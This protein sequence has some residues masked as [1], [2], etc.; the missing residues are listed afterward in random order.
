VT[1]PAAPARWSLP[2]I[3]LHWAGALVIP[4]LVVVGWAMLR[5]FGAATRFDLY[6]LHKSLGVLALALYA[7]RLVARA[8]TKAPPP[9][10]GPAWEMRAAR[11]THW[12]LYALTGVAILA[13]WLTASSAPLPIPTIVFGLFP[14]PDIAPR[15]PGVFAVVSTVHAWAAYGLA[16]LVALHAGAAVKHALWDR[17]GVMRRMV[18]QSRR[19]R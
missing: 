7:A 17:D 14:W 10:P 3:A 9:F 4:A 11:V 1:S 18:P 2:T 16:A 15:D 12:A 19:T 5:L 13:G 8:L 6:Q